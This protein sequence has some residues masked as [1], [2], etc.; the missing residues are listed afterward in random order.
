MERVCKNRTAIADALAYLDDQDIIHRDIKPANIIIAHD[1]TPKLADLV[2]V[3][4]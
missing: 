2:W 4:T 1:G 3:K